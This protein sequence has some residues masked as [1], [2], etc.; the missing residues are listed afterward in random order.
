MKAEDSWAAIIQLAER[1]AAPGSSNANLFFGFFARR[2]ALGHRF[3]FRD[4]GHVTNHGFDG[5]DLEDRAFLAT[6]CKGDRA[7]SH[8]EVSCCL[9]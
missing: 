1:V 8:V 4:L 9:A 2:P 3:D 5:A 7:N 6:N